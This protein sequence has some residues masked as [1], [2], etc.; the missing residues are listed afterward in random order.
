MGENEFISMISEESISN[1]KWQSTAGN[2]NQIQSG[3]CNF[4]K[5][6]L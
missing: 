3:P 4:S 5:M 6:E 1:S 2:N